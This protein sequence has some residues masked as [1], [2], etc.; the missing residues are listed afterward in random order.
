MM[1]LE[2][3]FKDHDF[4]KYSLTG[5]LV[6]LGKCCGLGRPG[7]TIK[8]SSEPVTEKVQSGPGFIG[9]NEEV[10]GSPSLNCDIAGLTQEP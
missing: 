6:K 4:T 1:H 9:E 7:R 8:F 10:I 5:I 3:K 2:A